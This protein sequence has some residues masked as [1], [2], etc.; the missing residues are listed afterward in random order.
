MTDINYLKERKQSLLKSIEETKKKKIEIVK[1]VQTLLYEFNS[2]RISKPE[3]DEKLSRALAGRTAEQWEEYYE[4]YIEYYDYQLKLCDKLIRKEQFKGI[5]NKRNLIIKIIAAMILLVFVSLLILGYFMAKTSIDSFFKSAAEKIDFGKEKIKITEDENVEAVEPIGDIAEPEAVEPSSVSAEIPSVSVEPG[6]SFEEETAHKQ[7]IAGETVKWQ[8]KIFIEDGYDFS[9][10]LPSDSVVK[11]V[12]R[13]E[14]NVKRDVDFDI[15]IKREFL[16]F[17]EKGISVEIAGSNTGITGNAV[18]R[19]KSS[20]IEYVIE[21]ETQGPEIFEGDFT[22]RRKTVVVRGSDEFHLYN[23]LSFASVP[24]T[25][26]IGEEG[27]IKVYQVF[28]D[29]KKEVQASIYDSNENGYLDYVEWLVPSLSEAVFEIVIEIS[30]A[31]HLDSNKN[32]ISDIYEEVKEQDGVWSE[33]INNNEYVRV[34]FK[35]ELD[36]T[37]DIILYVRSVG[38]ESIVEVYDSYTETKLGEFAVNSEGE[39]KFLLTE[40]AGFSDVFDLKVNGKIEI[41][42]IVDPTGTA[43]STC[44]ELQ[45]IAMT[46]SYY[47]ANNIDCSDTINWNSGAGFAPIGVSDNFFQGILDGNNYKITGLYINRPDTLRVGLF[48]YTYGAQILNLGIENANVQGKSSVGILAGQTAGTTEI[49]KVFT[50][51][52][53]KGGSVGT[54]NAIGGLA[55]WVENGATIEDSYSKAN[56]NQGIANNR[57]IGGLVGL[58]YGG[59]IRNSYATG[60]IFGGDELGGLVGYAYPSLSLYIYNSYATGEVSGNNYLGGLIGY[61]TGGGTLSLSNTYYSNSLSSCVGSG[62]FSGSCIKEN[63]KS[64]FYDKNGD[65]I[66]D[67]NHPV[68]SGTPEWDFE[69]IWNDYEHSYPLNF[70]TNLDS[71]RVL[72]QAGAVHIMNQNIV[73]TLG[74]NCI[75]ITAPDINLDCAGYSI[76]GEVAFAGIYSTAARTT[77]KNCNIDMGS[78]YP[79]SGIFLSSNTGSKIFDSSLSGSYFGLRLDGVSNLY[80]KNISINN[81]AAGIDFKSSSNNVL[82]DVKAN[83]AQSVAIQFRVSSSNNKIYDSNLFGST[84]SDVYLRQTSADNIFVNTNYGTEYVESG[85]ELV[86]KWYYKGYV[87]NGSYN[88]LDAIGLNDGVPIGYGGNT[89]PLIINGELILDG[90]DDFV[91]IPTSDELGLR[92]GNELTISAWINKDYS[93]ADGYQ[94][95]VKRGFDNSGNR[96]WQEYALLTSNNDIRFY[97]GNGLNH[98]GIGADEG[99]LILVNGVIN[100]GVWENIVV[101]LNSLGEVNFY[102]NGEFV[103]KGYKTFT[104]DFKT[105][106]QYPDN[107]VQRIGVMKQGDTTTYFKG[108]IDDVKVLNRVLSPEEVLRLYQSSYGN[109]LISNYDFE[110]NVLDIQGENEGTVVGNPQY[111][112]GKYGKS[113][114]FDGSDDYVK[115]GDVLDQQTNDF[116]LSA[117]VKSTSTAGGNG[118]GI[119]YKRGTAYAYSTGYRLN[120]P[121][122]QFN[123]H[124][125]DGTSY[126]SLTV[127]SV[128]EYNDN[129]WHYVAGVV[130]RGNELRLYVD[131]I[132]KGS[133]PN[134]FTTDISNDNAEFTIGGAKIGGGYYHPFDGSIDNVKIF[135]RDL[136]PQEIS[137]DYRSFLGANFYENIGGEVSNWKFE[138]NVPGANVVGKDKNNIERFNLITGKSGFSDLF[139][140]TDYINSGTGLSNHFSTYLINSFKDNMYDSHEFNSSLGTNLRDDF[141]LNNII[142]VRDCRV[143]DSQNTIYNLVKNIVD[144]TLTDNCINITAENITIDC[145]GH[146][147]TSEDNFTGVYSNQVNATI[148]NC[149][150]DM[151]SGGTGVFVQ[152]TNNVKIEN[153]NFGGNYYG[154]RFYNLSNGS[155]INLTTNN[156]GYRGISLEYVNNSIFKNITS[157]SNSNSGFY[158]YKSSNNSFENIKANGDNNGI[159]ILESSYNNRLKNINVDNNE[160][161]GMQIFS[162]D[163]IYIENI[164]ALGSVNGIAVGYSSN[165][166]IQDARASSNTNGLAFVAGVSNFVVKNSDFSGNSLRDVE[167]A[168]V[169]VNNTLINSTY[170]LNKEDVNF[171]SELIRKWYYRAYVK[172]TSG[173]IISNANVTAFNITENYNFNLTTDS[174]GYTQLR[175]IID[176][177]NR[178]SVRIYYSNY[179]IYADNK[180]LFDS[181]KFNASLGNNLKDVFTLR[182]SKPEIVLIEEPLQIRS[183]K[184][185]YGPNENSAR[186]VK[187]N[188][189]IYDAAGSELLKSSNGAVVS[190]S[191]LNSNNGAGGENTR[192]GNCVDL[193]KYTASTANY[194]CTILMQYWDIGGVSNPW[195]IHID[196]QNSKGGIGSKDSDDSLNFPHFRY[197]TLLA[198]NIDRSSIG[199][200]GVNAATTNIGANNDPIWI[201]NTGNVAVT[202][203][204]GDNTG[205]VVKGQDLN[206]INPLNKIYS[207]S[208]AASGIDDCVSANI[209]LTE[210]TAVEIVGVGY[211]R[212]PNSETAGKDDVF[213]CIKQIL[214]QP[215]KVDSY[216]TSIAWD[217]GVSDGLFLAAA[218]FVRRAKKKNEK[219][220]KLQNKEVINT[221]ELKIDSDNLAKVLGLINE[222]L[223]ERYG[224]NLQSL[225]SSDEKV[226]KAE[227]DIEIPLGLFKIANVGAAEILSKYLKDEKG[228]RFSEIEKLINRNQKTVALNYNNCSVKG[229]KIKVEKGEVVPLRIFSDRRLSVLESVVYYLKNQG[230]KNFEI[231]QMLDKDQRNIW[232]LYSRAVKKMS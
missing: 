90:V 124:I 82:K 137:E 19:E 202:A 104:G 119:I 146:S 210:N 140:I 197:G 200:T 31:E 34:T 60:D 62:T 83:S 6:V 172:D 70:A 184:V 1:I 144:N 167:N 225:L 21:Y 39:Y 147:I 3:Y 130:D 203:I 174:S 102:V 8:K 59:T 93:L 132:F 115:Y 26:K 32:F 66:S 164:S 76:T 98:D 189:T 114:D 30:N 68:Y 71:C 58:H 27:K 192:T 44:V 77:I 201:L 206:G 196:V 56:V 75:I 89:P 15:N 182:E 12:K 211:S 195:I 74:A 138:D 23:V 113:M 175:E 99:T 67:H 223:E 190:S 64:I 111:V 117:W 49:K 122:G 36:N 222:K 185:Y 228:F 28:N 127:G 53:V 166:F 118:N 24:E 94:G 155:I 214:P 178:D 180:S 143:L 212:R 131:G 171:S 84:N 65:S 218:V 129:E 193:G 149:N 205:V 107:L 128:G 148:R 18:A 120:M 80:A 79:S 9:V 5:G 48:G 45:A 133:I 157:N 85:S 217:L 63:S 38:E 110:D 20:N 194:S 33:A 215:L 179:T 207:E 116:T 227:E 92:E 145:Q 50:T 52:T 112:S 41:D 230:R 216:S 81:N 125:A 176:Y 73:Q 25:L 4:D 2:G 160:V 163:S 135:N 108:K 191:F 96:G 204:S 188:I 158:V 14:E 46:G 91:E 123:L 156:N 121:N 219:K 209:I 153:S 69:N 22:N 151:G 16:F 198:N 42:Y 95:V 231:A 168:R 17:G 61:N 136:S 55:G 220:S 101:T 187:F 229:K 100:P 105:N 88:Y 221:K 97:F 106:F 87:Q 7:V 183:P 29:G 170:D 54:N 181:H 103:L 10:D 186:I 161:V 165:G 47:L 142:K 43:I 150:V 152:N 169:S 35:K 126:S 208:F 51:G 199:W 40:L 86:R 109:G 139:E 134:T 162:S 13:V 11:S 72:N 141:I 232:T 154:V 177:I 224:V 173:D 57:Q 37:R 78:D 213:F 226:G 159:Y